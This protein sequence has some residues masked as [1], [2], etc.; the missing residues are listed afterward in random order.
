MA[1]WWIDESTPVGPAEVPYVNSNGEEYYEQDSWDHKFSIIDKSFDTMEKRYKEQA[2]ANKL[3]IETAF[4][5]TFG[6]IDRR[7]DEIKKKIEEF[8]SK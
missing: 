6:L 5:A 2:K 3:A 7:L 4:N 8:E 1:D